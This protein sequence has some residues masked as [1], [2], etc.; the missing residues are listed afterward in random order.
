MWIPLAADCMTDTINIESSEKP[1]REPKSAGN[2]MRGNAMKVAIASLLSRVSG[3]AREIA[4]AAA[5]GAS[6]AADA[7]LGAFRV[8]NLF[9]ELLAE[10]ALANAFV[11]MFADVSEKEGLKSG[12]RLANAFLGV[13]LLVSGVIT[14]ICTS[15]VPVSVV[16][17]RID[18]LVRV[19]AVFFAGGVSVCIHVIL[20][21]L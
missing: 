14:I 4:F 2:K 18:I 7:F 17:V 9:R 1:L 5:F 8:G 15:R 13:L 12:W 20:V 10:G 3:L 19:I 16:V 11:P 21:Q 6:A